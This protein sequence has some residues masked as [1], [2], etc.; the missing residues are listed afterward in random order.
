[1]IRI[2]GTSPRDCGPYVPYSQDEKYFWIN[3]ILVFF[4]EEWGEERGRG[5]RAPQPS[6][7]I[8]EQAVSLTKN[9]TGIIRQ[10]RS[11]NW[12]VFII[13]YYSVLTAIWKWLAWFIPYRRQAVIMLITCN[14][15]D[16]LSKSAF[17]GGLPWFTSW[18]LVTRS[19]EK[20]IKTEAPQH[21]NSLKC[22]T[23]CY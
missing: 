23:L 15:K 18:H 10:A 4:Y 17:E 6:S 16:Y 12:F 11:K 22:P 13:V 20:G 8:I 1:M 3:V 7:K 19:G 5:P 9:E 14:L 2:L 21:I